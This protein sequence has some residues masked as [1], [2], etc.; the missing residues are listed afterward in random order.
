MS[1]RCGRTRRR[2]RLPALDDDPAAGMD[3][4][5]GRAILSLYR[6]A[7]QPVMNEAGSRAAAAAA[8]PGL[9]L[10]ATADGMT[11]T[12]TDAPAGG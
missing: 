12:E 9:A 1:G 3:A 10:C 6:A 7:R 8:A 11:G 5:M 4:D 2:S